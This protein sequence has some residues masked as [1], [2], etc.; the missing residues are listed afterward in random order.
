MAVASGSIKEIKLLDTANAGVGT[1]SLRDKR[2]VWLLSVE[3]PNAYSGAAD[4]ASITGVGAAIKAKTNDG[5]TRTL[6]CGIPGA[7]G[8]DSNNQAV[9]FTGTAVQAATVSSD[10]LTGQL[11]DATGTE[12]TATVGASRGVKVLVSVDVSGSAAL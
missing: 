9:F 3:F 2:E 12:L 7:A 4:T 5:K 1:T 10:D 11:S 8:A 6:R